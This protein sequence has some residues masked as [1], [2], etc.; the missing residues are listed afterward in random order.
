MHSIPTAGLAVID[1]QQNVYTAAGGAAIGSF[2][3]PMNIVKAD[4]SGHQVFSAQGPVASCGVQ[5]GFTDLTVDLAGNVYTVGTINTNVQSGG[6]AAKLSADGSQF[7]WV[8]YLPAALATPVAI[9]V[10]TQN[11]AYIAGTTS[12]LHPF[13][14]KL[15]ADGSAFVYT[16]QFT[17]SGTTAALAVNDGG[18]VFVTGETSSSDFLVT[19]GAVQSK[20]PGATSAFVSKLDPAGNIVFSTFLGGAG[21]ANGQAIQVDSAGSIYV[22]GDAGPGFPTTPGSYQP[23]AVVPLWSIGPSAFVAKLQ[24]NG[25]AIVWATYAVV[26]GNDSGVTSPIKLAVSASDEVYLAS[27]TGAGFLPAPSAPQPCF[28]VAYDVVLL[29]LNAQGGLADS[30]YLRAS[31]AYAIAMTLPGDGSILVAATGD[32]GPVLAQIRFGQPG[33]TAAACLSA[34][35]LN[36]ASFSSGNGMISPGEL[37]SLTG[38]AIGPDSGVAYQLGPNGKVPVSLGGVQ[39]FFNGIPAPLLYV[40]SRQINAQV[41]FEVSTSTISTT[42]VAVTVT[43]N[44]QTFGPNTVESMWLGPAGIFRLHPGVSTQAAALNQDGS[45]NGPG[46]PA[47]RGSSVSFFGTGYGPLVPSCSTGG[48]NPPG[49]VPLYFTGTP[50][51]LPVEYEGSAPTRLCGIDQFNVQVPLTA[52]PGALVLTPYIN[53]GA[54]GSTIYIR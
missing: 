16:V 1:A 50:A 44:N 37:I 28:G 21:G 45:I 10:N 48:L 40:Q 2:C 30:T 19:A 33:W 20:L 27:S 14:T 49:P 12:D 24:P 6:F 25:S 38:F 46:N 26:N 13:V 15:S 34:D 31:R 54:Y 35:V 18:D 3:T 23:E 9:R 39:V 53:P 41:P 42:S 51:Q 47:L 4:S 22:S 32:A 43:Y 52:T 8:T 36:A 29:H 11:N 7:L 5:T 17:G